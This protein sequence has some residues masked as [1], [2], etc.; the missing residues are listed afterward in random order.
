VRTLPVI[1]V[2]ATDTVGPTRLRLL[3]AGSVK[4]PVVVVDQVDGA[5]AYYVFDV[6][7]LQ[8]AMTNQLSPTPLAAALDT[9]TLVARAPVTKAEERTAEPGSPVVENGR[10]I[11]VIAEDEPE[12]KEPGEEDMNRGASSSDSESGRKRGL[13]QRLSRSGE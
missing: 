11:G 6:A 5:P 1:A 3:T 13:W 4:L 7:T 2:N 9:D 12:R 10:L 8:A